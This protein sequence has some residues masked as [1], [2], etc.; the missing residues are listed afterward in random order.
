MHQQ[1]WDLAHIRMGDHLDDVISMYNVKTTSLTC[2]TFRNVMKIFWKTIFTFNI[3]LAIVSLLT[4]VSV[5]TSRVHWISTLC[6][7]C[8]FGR[9]AGHTCPFWGATGTP[10]LD[11]WWHFLWVLKPEWVLPYSLFAEANVIIYI[12][13]DPPLVLYIPTSCR[14]TSPPVLSPHTVAEMRLLRFELVLSEYL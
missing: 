10:V 3:R 9:F 14:P 5:L 6:K 1:R 2:P 4:K 12:P 8:V 7:L 13:Q 11:F